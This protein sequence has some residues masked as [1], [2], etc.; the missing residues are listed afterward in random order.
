MDTKSKKCC[1][2]QN[3]RN[4][5]NAAQD[6]A[7]VAINMA[8]GNEVNAKMVKDRTKAMNNNPRNNDM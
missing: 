6:Y 1:N 3:R 7:G 8:D 5:D 2:T 4:V